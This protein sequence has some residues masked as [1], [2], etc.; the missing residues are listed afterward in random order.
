[1]N[2]GL[3]FSLALE[4]LCLRPDQHRSMTPDETAAMLK[5]HRRRQ[6]RE[7]ERAAW[8]IAWL[9]PRKSRNG[10]GVT[11]MQVLSGAPGYDPDP[12]E[13]L[14]PLKKKEEKPAE[15]LDQL[16]SVF[17]RLEARRG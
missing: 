14:S 2:P 3:A 5:A 13:V 16:N 1:M 8:R 7:M 6:N 12:S 10:H 9:S 11:T 15:G 4:R 17:E